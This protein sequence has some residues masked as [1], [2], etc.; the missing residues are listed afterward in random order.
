MRVAPWLLKAAFASLAVS[1]LVA[2]P[3]AA[4]AQGD[5]KDAEKAGQVQIDGTDIDFGDDSSR[6]ANDGECDDPRFIG[7][8]SDE[9][10]L[11]EDEMHD[12][13]DCSAAFA[14]GTARLIAQ[15]NAAAQEGSIDFG[16]DASEWA[17]DRECDDPRFV[18]AG[19]AEN[20][21]DADTSHDATDCR[22]A[23]EAGTVTL[24]EEG[25][26]GTAL[27]AAGIDFGDDASSY[28]FDTRCDDPRFI[29]TGADLHNV[30]ADLG[31]DATDCRAAFEG[32]TISLQSEPGESTEA[33]A[34]VDTPSADQAPTEQVAPVHYPKADQSGIDFGSNDGPWIN[35]RQCDDPR[36]SGPG[37]A[38]E[39][40]AADRMHDAEDCRAAFEADAVTFN[41]AAVPDSTGTQ[42]PA[43][44]MPSPAPE[45]EPPVAPAPS[46]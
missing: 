12:A 3:G 46:P 41:D 6:W 17:S 28:A 19:A 32:G 16:D 14:G 4:F 7:S 21:V 36:F 13:S 20:N 35:D 44:E 39:Q 8:A 45:T 34:G 30:E 37:A 27:D 10:L 23:Y 11:P 31:H 38:V 33:P 15:P 43:Q 25:A 40:N 1:I 9:R 29:G 26:A 22:A 24:N 2:A 5:S 18:G 42:I